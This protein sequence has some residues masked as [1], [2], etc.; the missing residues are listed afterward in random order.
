MSDEWDADTLMKIIAEAIRDRDFRAMEAAIKLLALV[1]A[2]KAQ[3]VYDS[4]VAVV[5][6]P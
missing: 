6:R 1:D 2:R 5:E 4:L 3:R